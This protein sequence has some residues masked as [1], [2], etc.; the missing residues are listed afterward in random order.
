MFLA[1]VLADNHSV[2]QISFHRILIMPGFL[3]DFFVDNNAVPGFTPLFLD[4]LSKSD[5]GEEE[6]KKDTYE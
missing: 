2:F 1:I 3:L 5:A 6:G 4:D